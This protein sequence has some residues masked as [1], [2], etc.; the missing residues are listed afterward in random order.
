MNI[1]HIFQ[2]NEFPKV[3]CIFDENEDDVVYAP[4]Y[5]SAVK[6]MKPNLTA[7][8]V[9]GDMTRSRSTLISNMTCRHNHILNHGILNWCSR[10][11]INRGPNPD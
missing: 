10:R 5:V 8:F 7:V 2:L 6:E 4:L 3:C 11:L 9:D 1:A